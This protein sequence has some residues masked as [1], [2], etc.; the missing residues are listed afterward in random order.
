MDA[1]L[2]PRQDVDAAGVIYPFYVQL[3]Y[4]DNLSIRLKICKQIYIQASQNTGQISK[5]DLEI[6]IKALFLVKNDREASL[7]S[8]LK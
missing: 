4:C 1:E 2:R 6:L 8:A 5:C 7:V 3:A